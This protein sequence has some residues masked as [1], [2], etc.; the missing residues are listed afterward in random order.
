MKIFVA[1]FTSFL[2]SC[3]AIA[4]TKPKKQAPPTQKEMED[5]MK[6]AQDA[7]R[8]LDPETK[9]MMDS[10]GIKMPAVKEVPKIGDKALAE[11]WERQTAIVP[12]KDAARISMVPKTV[13]SDAAL[14]SFVQKVHSAVG[15]KLTAQNK[16]I[17]ERVY[18]SVRS[19]STTAAANAASGL[20]AN[21]NTAIAVYLMGKASLDDPSNP[22]NLN[23]YA[24]F[25]TMTGAE[26]AA[27]PILLN[28][29]KKYPNNST[30]LNNIGQAW[31]G[32]GE[33]DNA[34]KYLDSA[35]LFFA[36]HAQANFTKCLIQESKGGDPKK[37]IDAMKKSIAE[38]YSKEKE[39]KLRDLGYEL[40]EKDLNWDFPIPADALGLERFFLPRYPMK[41]GEAASLEQEW[42]AFRNACNERIKELEAKNVKLRAEIE[43]Q[44]LDVQKEMMT[45][46]M[47]KQRF[48]QP[49]LIPFY[50]NKALK[51]LKYLIDDK[52][53]RHAYHSRRIAQEEIDVKN[54]VSQ[55][56]KKMQAEVGKLVNSGKDG[57]GAGNTIDNSYCIKANAIIDNYLPV[58]NKLLYDNRLQF[59]EHTRKHINNLAYFNLFIMDPLTYEYTQNGLKIT[60]LH[61]LAKSQVEFWRCN[62]ISVPKEDDGTHSK[63][64]PDFD[65][66]H[67]DRHVEFYFIS[68]TLKLD[69]SRLTSEINL[70]VL[71]MSLKENLNTN[72]IIRG[73]VQVGYFRGTELKRGPVKGEF[74]AEGSVAVEFDKSGVTDVGVRGKA[75]AGSGI[76]IRYGWNSGGSV[77]GKGILRGINLKSP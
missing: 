77:E 29:N 57:E 62:I 43:Q 52:D 16:T 55:L 26:E 41:T 63:I 46:V 34:T 9:R 21:G 65:D 37:A 24:A 40:N 58:A 15:A 75:V 45:A 22:D 51:K 3:V 36:L 13:M 54:K 10:M 66:I 5:M 28:L 53:G 19:N 32:L 8:N 50:H 76:E 18:E 61:E 64:I 27:L 56:H 25:L 35:I 74:R 44:A 67:C 30:V 20:W 59:L 2:V 60:W 49:R 69:C 33:L 31:F 11:E 68:T 17:A 14:T 72:E 38:A 1:V 7:L 70:P 47:N 42:K 6:Q 12:K 23:N 48:G 39:D 71:K 4:Q 73:T